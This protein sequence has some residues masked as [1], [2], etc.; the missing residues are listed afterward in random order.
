MTFVFD[1]LVPTSSVENA[2][3]LPTPQQAAMT[4][5]PLASLGTPGLVSPLLAS[6]LVRAGSV[7]TSSTS[8]P[9]WNAVRSGRLLYTCSIRSQKIRFL[10]AHPGTRSRSPTRQTIGLYLSPCATSTTSIPMLHRVD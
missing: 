3:F 2:P 1:E 9:K 7:G 10:A 5:S 4:V 8:S 6:R